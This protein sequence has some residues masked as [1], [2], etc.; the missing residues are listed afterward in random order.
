VT[1]RNTLFTAI[2][3]SRA[4]VRITGSGEAM[5]PIATEVRTVI[6]RQ[7]QLEFKIPTPEELATIRHIHRER[8]AQ[9]QA[10]LKRATKGLT[11]FLEALER[12]EVDVA[13]L[14]PELRTRLTSVRSETDDAD[15]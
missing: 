2:T 4:W 12:G 10:S 14:P 6:E 11:T 1:R 3:R 8:P 7:F 5:A 9:H 13:D 15:E